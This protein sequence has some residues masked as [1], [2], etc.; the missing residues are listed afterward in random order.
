MAKNFVCAADME[1]KF[2]SKPRK[3][4][5]KKKFCFWKKYN[6]NRFTLRIKDK[7]KK[8]DP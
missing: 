8:F 2:E 7:L 3:L 6:F 1:H 4:R 5:F